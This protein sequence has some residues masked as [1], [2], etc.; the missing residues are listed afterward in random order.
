MRIDLSDPVFVPETNSIRFGVAFTVNV[1]GRG[2][3]MGK[4]WFS[5]MFQSWETEREQN[6]KKRDQEDRVHRGI[7]ALLPQFWKSIAEMI[8]V[9]FGAFNER[10]AEQHRFRLTQPE[11][12]HIEAVK[13]GYPK[14]TLSVGIVPD[15][16]LLSFSGTPLGH[17]GKFYGS[18][19]LAIDDGYI[20]IEKSNGPK[21]VK[22]HVT[23]EEFEQEML[24]PF[25][26]VIL[27]SVG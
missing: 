13:D 3:S 24:G 17:E 10:V 2:E 23:L 12:Y 25:L 9:R 6:R 22:I 15:L 26:S 20:Y 8:K 14:A 5:E 16:S 19:H 1:Q 4:D 7:V 18:Y 11:E 27:K 21:S